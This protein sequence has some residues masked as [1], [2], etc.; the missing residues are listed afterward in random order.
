LVKK[1]RKIQPEIQK[2]NLFSNIGRLICQNVQHQM[3]NPRKIEHLLFATKLHL[4]TVD[5]VYMQFRL[6][7]KNY[8]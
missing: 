3:Q 7:K 1:N 6:H 5:A 8:M 4:K 2:K